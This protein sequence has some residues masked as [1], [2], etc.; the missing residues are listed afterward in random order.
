MASVYSSLSSVWSLHGCRATSS[1]TARKVCFGDYYWHGPPP[2]PTRIVGDT[3]GAQPPGRL[4][5]AIFPT[6]PG[7]ESI[8]FASMKVQ[9]IDP[10]VALV[11]LTSAPDDPPVSSPE[12]Q[13]ELG[14]LLHSLR[15]SG[16]VVSPQYAADGGTGLSGRFVIRTASL[17]P[18]F[19]TVLKE[20][21]KSRYGRRAQ[22][23]I[24]NSEVEAQTAEEVARL[25]KHTR[26]YQKIS[27]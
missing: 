8:Y 14:D 12:Y 5:F 22:L 23:K 6:W 21:I 3:F 24:G 10:G 15:A 18:V 1:N 17:G 25:L 2:K 19:E 4:S 26:E 7:T 16:V 9:G 20:W 11:H 13:R 27:R